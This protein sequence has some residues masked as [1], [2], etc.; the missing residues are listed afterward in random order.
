MAQVCR[1]L[2]SL[3]EGGGEGGWLRCIL[4]RIL[5]HHFEKCYIIMSFDREYLLCSMY[6]TD[7]VDFSDMG[8]YYRL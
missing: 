3:Q 1:S 2:R 6:T 5:R 7:L 4:D 8:H